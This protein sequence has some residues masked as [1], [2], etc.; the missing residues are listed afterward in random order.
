MMKYSSKALGMAVSM[1]LLGN[2]AFAADTG[3]GEN[4]DFARSLMIQDQ[5]QADS[6]QKAAKAVD[7]AISNLPELNTRLRW[8]AVKSP[9]ELAEEQKAAQR[10]HKAIP[11][12]ITAAD[13][14]KA[15]K[16]EKKQGK[17]TTEQIISP[18][19]LQQPE[20]KPQ[21]PVKPQPVVQPQAPQPVREN[22]VELP[23]IQPIGQ[24]QPV[25]QPPTETVEL[26]PVQ[27]VAPAASTLL[28]ALVEVTS[29]ELQVRPVG[30]SNIMELTIQPVR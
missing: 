17:K 23:P 16:E 9:Q 27:P 11:I 29:V 6:K 1:L 3:A 22:V 8:A 12:I 18:R 10:Q 28:D 19:P 5:P 26:S 21:M 2:V 20:L 25:S 15:R 7:N 13:V 4:S 30:D 24:S 14:D